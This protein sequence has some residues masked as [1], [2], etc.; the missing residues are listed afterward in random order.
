MIESKTMVCTFT[1]AYALSANSETLLQENFE[2][3]AL[4]SPYLNNSAA[5][6]VRS[7]TDDRNKVIQITLPKG[8]KG[9]IAKKIAL[10]RPETEAC[11]EYNVYYAKDFEFGKEGKLPGFAGGDIV[12]ACVPSE[13]GFKNR[14]VWRTG[15]ELIQYQYFPGK[16]TTCGTKTQ[17]KPPESL[18]TQ[19]WHTIKSC[20]TLGDAGKDNGT[21]EAWLDGQ[22]GG[23]HSIRW[24]NSND[25]NIT[26]VMLVAHYSHT[27][28]TKD[29]FIYY[30]NIRAYTIDEHNA[31]SKNTFSSP[32]PPK[33]LDVKAQ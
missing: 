24:R 25:V 27:E 28:T 19:R 13:Y 20:I 2:R 26:H 23:K 15:G 1:L 33:I 17:V 32:S 5:K 29:N 14:F 12:G 4:G 3:Y 31:S 7:P 16:K 18:K 9:G 22:T 6:I 10:N 8:G 11:L 30:D 21:W